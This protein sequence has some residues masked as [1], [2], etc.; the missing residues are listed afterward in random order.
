MRFA[1]DFTTDDR[2]LFRAT[3][4]GWMR[5]RSCP[6][7]SLGLPAETEARILGGNAAADLQA[8]S[9]RGLTPR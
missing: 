6:F 3:I 7:R 2:L 9:P 1:L 8:V 4:P 5:R